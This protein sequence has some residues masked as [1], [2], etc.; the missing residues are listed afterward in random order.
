MAL[1]FFKK[2]EIVL[3][4]FTTIPYIYDN[5]R[6]NYGIK[7]M[8]EWWVNTPRV[9]G[10]V[11]TIKNCI[12]LTEFYKRG[13]VIPSWF[14]MEMT[15]N[16]MGQE[17]GYKWE[18]SNQ[19]V[20]TDDSHNTA[21][22]SK[23]AEENGANIKLS[24]PWAFRTDDEVYFS[25]TQ[26][27]WHF[28]SLLSKMTILPGVINFKYQHHTNINFFAQNKDV[29][30]QCTIPPLTPLVIMHPLTDKKVIIKNHLVS[31]SEYDRMFG[32][33]KLLLKRNGKEWSKFYTSKQKL[34]DKIK[35]VNR[36]PFS[37]N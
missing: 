7:Y 29:A 34:K 25:W 28:R 14:E 6:I 17:L 13:I 37:G 31:E 10:D 3:D 30:E 33:G 15:I 35:D 22:F 1:F 18:S 2:K 4:C 11:P 20:R 27:T 36:C 9:D 21:Q 24:S 5:A 12:A 8:P 16:Q 19:D 26:P 23:F 32:L